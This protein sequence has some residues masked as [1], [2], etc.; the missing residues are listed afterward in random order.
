MAM[1]STVWKRDRVAM[2]PSPINENDDEVIGGLIG[3]AGGDSLEYSVYEGF[4]SAEIL[5]SAKNRLGC[6]VTSPMTH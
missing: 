4:A 1:E 2:T 6:E 5:S 3:G